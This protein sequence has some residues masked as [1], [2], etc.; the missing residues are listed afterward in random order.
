VSQP[1]QVSRIEDFSL[2][3]IDLAV[4]GRDRYDL[5]VA[6]STKY[7]PPHA[8]FENWEA[9]QRIKEKFFG[10]HRD[11]PPEDIAQRLGGTI[12][13]RE[14]RNGQWIAVIAVEQ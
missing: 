7:Q 1:F 14:E 11:L 2:P 12:A 9:W 6:F 3:Q 13:Y 8:L 10:Y 4:G 5:L